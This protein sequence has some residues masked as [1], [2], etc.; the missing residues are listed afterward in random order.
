[1]FSFSFLDSD[2]L[3]QGP[4]S[5]SNV[6]FQQPIV[7]HDCLYAIENARPRIYRSVDLS[8][9]SFHFFVKTFQRA[10]ISR[11][12]HEKKNQILY[13]SFVLLLLFFVT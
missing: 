2:L 9:I 13:D 10:D 7:V 5:I 3:L 12:I 6:C 8:I 1:M 4:V 11:R